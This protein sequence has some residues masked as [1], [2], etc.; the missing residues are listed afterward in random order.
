MHYSTVYVLKLFNFHLN[1]RRI[2]DIT[3]T[4]TFIGSIVVSTPDCHAENLLQGTESHLTGPQVL[5]LVLGKISRIKWKNTYLRYGIWTRRTV[6]RVTVSHCYLIIVIL[7]SIFS[8][9]GQSGSWGENAGCRAESTCTTSVPP[10][11]EKSGKV[12]SN[13]M[14]TILFCPVECSRQ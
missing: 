14:A 8:L 2:N 1:L 9:L 6:G 7:S 13:S 3:F 11:F 12:K 10:K 5:W 4:Q